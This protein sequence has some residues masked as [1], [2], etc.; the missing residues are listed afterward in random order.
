[1]FFGMYVWLNQDTDNA[2]STFFPRRLIHFLFVA[3]V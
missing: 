3:L 1:M 2:M